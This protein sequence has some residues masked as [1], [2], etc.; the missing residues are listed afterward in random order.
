MK[1]LLSLPVL[2]LFVGLLSGLGT[3]IFLT[4]QAGGPLIKAALAARQKALDARPAREKGWDFWTIEIENLA[5]ELR[6]ERARL[7]H[8]SE[9][10]DQRR[11]QLEN[12]QQQLAAVR[13]DLESLRADIG[14][15]VI[16][17]TTDESKNIRTLAQTYSNLTPS[18]AVAVMRELDDNTVVKILS[19][20]KP[21]IVAPIF[22]EMSHTPDADGTLAKRAATLS[23]KLRLVHVAKVATRS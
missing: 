10:I 11:A 4:W 2:T 16:E 13:T 21:D 7:R 19:Q 8:E 22:E 6:D 18:G 12:E 3:G 17:L 1:K 15:R 14:R 9:L 20:M 23:D 5:N